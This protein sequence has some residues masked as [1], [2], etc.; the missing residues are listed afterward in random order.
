MKTIRLGWVAVG[1]LIIS[2]VFCRGVGAG[3]PAL[4][5][6]VVKVK[7]RGGWAEVM[8][9]IENRTGRDIEFQCCKA[10]LED[11]DGYAIASLSN[12]EVGSQIYNKARTPAIIGAILGGGLGLGGAISGK[13]ELGYAAL[14]V[15]GASAIAGVAGDASAEKRHRE[16]V[17][18]D[19]MRN[20]VFPAGLKVAGIV[21]FPPKKK[22]PGSK[23]GQAIHLTYTM[24][25]R[26]HRVTAPFPI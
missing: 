6:E 26:L 23:Q 9:A 13:K 25:G 22:W 19:I 16:L 15:A 14:G 3:E 11:T 12:R 4:G 21:Y 24:N 20:Q 1:C 18:D 5:L 10:F 7:H 17:I 8:I 2:L